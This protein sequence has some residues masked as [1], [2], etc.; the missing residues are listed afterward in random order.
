MPFEHCSAILR[1]GK[2]YDI[3]DLLNEGLKRF[4]HE[5]PSK[6][7]A[8]DALYDRTALGYEIVYEENFFG[9]A[10]SLAHELSIN[11]SLPGICL[12]YIQEADAVRSFESSCELVSIKVDFVG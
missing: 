9:V 5:F 12:A 1:L 10:L 3:E 4:R 11:Q 8:W 7:S 6:L 2:K